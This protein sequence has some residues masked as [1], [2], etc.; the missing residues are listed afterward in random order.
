M[1]HDFCF[2]I[3]LYVQLHNIPTHLMTSDVCQKI[4]VGIPLLGKAASRSSSPAHEKEAV[5]NN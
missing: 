1:A 3:E 4:T 5:N 2:I